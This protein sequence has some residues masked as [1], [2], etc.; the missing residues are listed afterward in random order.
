[1]SLRLDVTNHM[2][3]YECLLIQVVVLQIS[4]FYG[5]SHLDSEVY[6]SHTH[7]WLVAMVPKP[8]CLGC[9][10]SL[11]GSL[12]YSYHSKKN[13]FCLMVWSCDQMEGELG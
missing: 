3:Y 1:M 6:S 4:I 2:R 7:S 12:E 8:F 5:V 10:R 9:P 13:S 11:K